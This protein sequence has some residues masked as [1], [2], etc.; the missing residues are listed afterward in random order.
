MIAMPVKL[1]PVSD[2]ALIRSCSR[3]L[4][5]ADPR[6]TEKDI[7]EAYR[8]GQTAVADRDSYHAARTAVSNSGTGPRK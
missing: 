6:V 4:A 8:G 7:R 5:S 1:E 2:F 3:G